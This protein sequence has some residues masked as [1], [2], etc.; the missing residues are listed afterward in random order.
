MEKSLGEFMVRTEFNPDKN[1]LV[2]QIK[3]KTA[4]LIN[5]TEQCR[6]KDPRLTSLAQTN[7]ENAAMWALKAATA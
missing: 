5:L 3:Q 1:D 2:N 6:I 7:Y 4:E